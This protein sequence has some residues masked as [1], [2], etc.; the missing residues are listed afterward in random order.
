MDPLA[1][2]TPGSVLRRIYEESTA[3]E[4][5]IDLLKRRMELDKKYTDDLKILIGSVVP[6]WPSLPALSLVSPML[7][8]FQNGKF[9]SFALIHHWQ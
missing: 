7:R 2:D 4:A 9:F 6:Q 1:N 3:L 5:Y 8:H